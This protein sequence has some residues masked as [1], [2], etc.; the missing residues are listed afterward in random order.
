[1]S[2]PS[3][4][5][6]ATVVALGCAV[7]SAAAD[8]PPKPE[9]KLRH[10]TVKL[11]EEAEPPPA[12]LLVE[13]TNLPLVGDG[14][15]PSLAVTDLGGGG[16]ANLS[17]TFS[18]VQEIPFL[19]P[20]ARIWKVLLSVR[21]MEPNSELTRFVGLEVGNLG[22]VVD[23]TIDNKTAG[24][25]T[26]SVTGPPSDLVLAESR[27]ASI[28]VTTGDRPATGVRIVQS[29]LQDVESKVT[30][31][32][33][34]LELSDGARIA[35]RST[36]ELVLGVKD[37]FKHPGTFAGAVT[38]AVDQQAAVQAVNLTVHS[39][40]GPH[41]F[42]GVVFIAL[43]IGVS[44]FLGVYGKQRANRLEALHAAAVLGDRLGALRPSLESA[45]AKRAMSRL[46]ALYADLE[47]QLGKEYLDKQGLLPPLWPDASSDDTRSKLFAD[48][49]TV[50]ARLLRNVDE[51]AVRGID[52]VLRRWDAAQPASFE[53]ALDALDALADRALTHD[54]VRAGVDQV[55]AALPRTD[56]SFAGV[57]LRRRTA[58]E[59]TVELRNLRGGVWIVWA[60]VTV[61]LGCMVL[62]FNDPGFGG[63]LDLLK[64]FFWGLGVQVAGQQLQELTPGKVATRFG[65]PVPAAG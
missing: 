45:E 4:F 53:E 7:T 2:R 44:L 26:W 39:S 32:T 11:G 8:T 50:M 64:C 31:G 36:K 41:R 20:S 25:F 6:V 54:Q 47:T 15:S 9:L 35:A 37:R 56:A 21:G 5:L 22:T 29:S 38:L 34:H 46:R 51:I 28:Y 33:E 48:H 23:L 42:F 63:C 59:L 65:L 30:L 43:G 1:M 55:R 3:R 62:I 57:G 24:S 27:R 16:P 60:A 12:P 10:A 58:G 52:E 17:V 61:A 40:S 18:V 19:D 49:L 14:E 13:A